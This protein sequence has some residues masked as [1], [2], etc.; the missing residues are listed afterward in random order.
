MAFVL[1]P[2]GIVYNAKIR[3]IF[4]IALGYVILYSNLPH[5]EVRFLFPVLP[6]WNICAAAGLT[7]LLSKQSNIFPYGTCKT[8]TSSKSAVEMKREPISLFFGLITMATVAAGLLAGVV[9]TVTSLVA[10]RANYPGGAA[11]SKLHSLG[12]DFANQASLN[13][14]SIH[15]HIGVLPA[16]TGVSRFGE[17]GPPWVYSKT[18]DIDANWLLENSIDFALSA[19]ETIEGFNVMQSI[20]GYSRLEIS[21]KSPLEMLRLVLRGKSPLQMVTTPQVYIHRK[22]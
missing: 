1:A 21:S 6:L 14:E 22:R 10:S 11:L 20:D 5:K 18:E 19:N 8:K 3:P 16:M 15:V 4:V 13:N 7:G 2:I 9:L 12:S 17:L